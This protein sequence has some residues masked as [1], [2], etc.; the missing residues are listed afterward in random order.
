V[1]FSREDQDLGSGR[2]NSFPTKDKERIGGG[3]SVFRNSGLFSEGGRK[4][5]QELGM[6]TCQREGRSENTYL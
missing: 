2:T 4:F 3:D 5:E 1:P 6:E